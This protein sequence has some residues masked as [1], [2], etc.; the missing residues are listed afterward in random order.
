MYTVQFGAELLCLLVNL[1]MDKLLY[2]EV[3]RSSRNRA[4]SYNQ[5]YK[6]NFGELLKTVL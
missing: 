4:P 1:D 2:V 3:D 5:P 6:E